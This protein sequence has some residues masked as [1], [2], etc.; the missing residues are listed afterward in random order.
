MT[1]PWKKIAR[2]IPPFMVEILKPISEIVEGNPPQGVTPL[3]A[4]GNVSV[5]QPDKVL[6]ISGAV[7]VRRDDK[8][9][10]YVI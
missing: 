10:I 8:Y 7:V 4:F 9:V 5:L 1:N 6:I 3:L 2:Y